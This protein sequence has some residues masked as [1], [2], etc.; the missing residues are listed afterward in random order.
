MSRWLQAAG[1]MT[2]TCE[3]SKTSKTCKTSETSVS[4]ERLRLEAVAARSALVPAVP[5]SPRNASAGYVGFAG[6]AGFEGFAG[7]AGC[8]VEAR[9]A[10]F[11]SVEAYR[12]QQFRYWRAGLQRLLREPIASADAAYVRNAQRFIEQGW[13]LKALDLG[14]T[15]ASLFWADTD[16]PWARVDRLGA[17]YFGGVVRA[18]T[19]DGI[20]FEHTPGSFQTLRRERSNENQCPPWETCFLGETGQ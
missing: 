5:S 4:T 7:S 18:I 2:P 11:P 19:A 15:E 14:W 16:A 6:F 17:A 1:V 12:R 8:E 10:G 9:E 20:R 13:A 3:T